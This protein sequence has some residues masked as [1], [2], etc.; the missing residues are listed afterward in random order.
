MRV[1]RVL[2]VLLTVVVGVQAVKSYETTKRLK[3]CETVLEA[4]AEAFGTVG[5]IAFNQ[6]L[7]LD[8]LNTRL[9]EMEDLSHE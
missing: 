9:K 6:S 7:R 5:H 2:L 4:Y 8:D 3:E 1:I